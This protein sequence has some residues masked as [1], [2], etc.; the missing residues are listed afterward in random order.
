M[1]DPQEICGQWGNYF[2][3]LYT[4]ADSEH[5]DIGHYNNVISRVDEL[6]RQEFSENDVVLVADQELNEAIS[7]LSRGKACGEDRIDN[8]HIMYSGHIFRQLLVTLYNSML[9]KS[10]IPESMKI[11]IIITLY[12]GGGKRKDDPNS[13][14]AITLTSSV[15]KLFERILLKRILSVQRPF[16]PLQGGFQKGM[17]CNMTSF[18]LQ[19]SVHYARENGSKLYICFLDAKKA[20]DKVWHDGLFLKLYETGIELYLWKI[21]VSLH[22]QVS[23]YVLF[24]GFK[25]NVFSVTQGTRQGGVISPHLFLCFIN[26]LLNMLCASDKGFSICGINVCCPTVA[27]DM[28]LQSL[29]KFGLQALIDICVRYFYRWRLEYNVMKCAVLVCNESDTEFKRSKRRWALGDHELT[30][31]DKYTHLGIVCNKQMDMKINTMESSSKIRRIFFGLVVSSFCERDL[32]PLTLKRIYD[33]VVLPK[34]LYGCELW[35]SMSQTDILLLERSHRLCLKTIQEIDR[36]TRTCVALGL[37]GSSDLKYEIEKRKAT[38][39]GQLC[40]LDPHFAVK[41]LFLQRVTAHYFFKDVKYGFII[42]IFRFLE[43]YNFVHILIEYLNSGVFPSKFEW[44]KLVQETLKQRATLCTRFE[45]DSE[46]LGRFLDIHSRTKP[47]MFWELSWKYPYMLTACRSVVKL[48]AMLFNRYQPVSICSACG[49][50]VVNYV[51][52]CLLCCH[53][54][55]GVRHKMWAGFL[56]KFGANVYS[57]LAKL[58]IDS[59]TDVLLGNFEIIADVLS[60]SQKDDFYCYVARFIHIQTVC[61]HPRSFLSNNTS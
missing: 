34:A 57:C 19:E 13:Y 45:I 2:S 17:G 15:L 43:E 39:F 50:L 46:G 10:Y 42:D 29:T 36:K 55:S 5:F 23:S 44:K 38:F 60:V 11:G 47:S 40:R 49:E 20:F 31:T 53:A 24:K 32:H 26:D 61:L 28:L 6:K 9:L 51:S 7:Q 25:S 37:I 30:E 48:I 52:H 35:S 16:N 12:K 41:R 18:L 33:T 8:E 14:R 22:A 58:S 27:D 3:S 59:L 56:R 21:L 4:A 1:R 54:N